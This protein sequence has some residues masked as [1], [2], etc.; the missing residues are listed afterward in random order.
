MAADTSSS[1]AASTPVVWA[2][3]AAWAALSVEPIVP[4]SVAAAV[5]SS[6]AA[7]TLDISVLLRASSTDQ[8]GK[9]YRATTS[10]DASNPLPVFV[11][12]CTEML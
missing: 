1:A 7:I 9:E 6:G 8:D 10:S 12:T 5:I 11:S 4:K 2:A 3:A